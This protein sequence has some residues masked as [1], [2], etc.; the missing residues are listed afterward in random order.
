MMHL[1][2]EKVSKTMCM[3]VFDCIKHGMRREPDMVG[4]KIDSLAAANTE[5]LADMLKN[6]CRLAYA[7][8]PFYADKPIF[9]VNQRN[10]IAPKVHFDFGY[11]PI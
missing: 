7:L 10:Q 6:Q 2:D 1:V 8:R 4:G 9:P 5:R 3:E 11:K